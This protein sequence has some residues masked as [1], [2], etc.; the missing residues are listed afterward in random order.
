[1]TRTAE[2]LARLVVP[3]LAEFTSVDLLDEVLRGE[4][5][6][7]GPPDATVVLRRAAHLSTSSTSEGTP[8]AVVGLGSTDTYPPFSP[9]ARALRSGQAVL[10]GSGEP[11]FDRW[12]HAVPARGEMARA[13]EP[14]SMMAVPLIARGTTLGVAVL[15]RSR[16]DAFT[17][18]D[19][20]L[21]RE[22]AGRAAVCVDN[23]RRYTHER[24]TA[25]VLQESLLPHGRTRQAAVTVATRYLPAGSR[26]GVGGDWFDVIPLSGARVALVVGD[27]VGHGIHASATMGRLRT[28]VR[29]LADVDLPPDELL[30][31]LDD[32]VIRLASEDEDDD[33]AGT[34]GHGGGGGSGG[35]GGGET[36]AT[37]L[38]AVYDPVA[39]V[40]TAAS[41]GHP[42]PVV[43]LP[44]GTADVPAITPGP[45]LG[46][47]GL[48][49]EATELELPEGSLLALYSDGLVT[50]RRRDAGAGIEELRH[51]LTAPSEPS[52]AD[53][54]EASCDHVIETLLPEP[55]RPADDVALLLAR[56]SALRADKVGVWDLAAD[57]SVV[58][59]ARK[60]AAERLAAWE[61]G[62]EV[63]F[64]TELVVSELVTNAIRY[65]AAPIQLRLIHDSSLI[66][67][68]SDGNST[69]PHLRRARVFDEGGR[70]LLLIAQLTHRWGTRHTG[71][72]KTIWA[73][74][75]LAR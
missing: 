16:P 58:A 48:P 74:Q 29:T 50:A 40:C 1:M 71:T 37:C 4:E 7:A 54:L 15:F 31:H 6:A 13:K 36:G 69:S 41:A 24:S 44:D 5:P 72:G 21:G 19:V 22:L 30:A 32:L 20:T 12:T 27:V 75:T 70:G 60:L 18:D 65:G 28:A 33:V 26:A 39:R 63:A 34:G 46:V 3:M 62:D 52:P 17:E 59:D 42:P 23:A 9:P 25:L 57:P 2:E 66:C 14:S 35:G 61:L 10:S 68:V 11:D 43:V 64:V 53:A 49:F 38:Y 67:E 51:I 73:E 45:V 55:E 8:E 47:G 56:T